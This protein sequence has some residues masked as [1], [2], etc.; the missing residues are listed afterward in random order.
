MFLFN[1]YRFHNYFKEIYF[2]INISSYNIIAQDCSISF[3][4]FTN[5]VYLYQ[6]ISCF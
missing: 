2:F 4:L 5:I 1:S 6:A 3:K